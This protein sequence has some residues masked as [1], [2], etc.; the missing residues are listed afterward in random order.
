M[1]FMQEEYEK[2]I[3]FLNKLLLSLRVLYDSKGKIDV[4]ETSFRDIL[5]KKDKSPVY[6]LLDLLVD[7]DSDKNNADVKKEQY[8]KISSELSDNIRN[9][10][11]DTPAQVD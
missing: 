2:N 5:K 1:D 11:K 8:M 10:L 6:K 3:K 9:I 7:K 4:N